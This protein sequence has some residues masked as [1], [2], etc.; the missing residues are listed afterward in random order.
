MMLARQPKPWC[1]WRN[2][3]RGLSS[4]IVIDATC[5]LPEEGGPASWPPLSRE[6]LE[7]ECPEAFALVDGQ[8]D[9]YWR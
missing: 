8:W 3:K 4:K 5:Q 1:P 9:S 7:K 6:Q 2:P